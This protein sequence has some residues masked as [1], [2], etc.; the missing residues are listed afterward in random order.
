MVRRRVRQVREER[1]LRLVLGG[2]TSPAALRGWELLDEALVEVG[3]ELERYLRVRERT[4]CGEV[5]RRQAR[6][7]DVTS[8]SDE[9]DRDAA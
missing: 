6:L 1:V 7:L 5:R 3:P 2:L 9:D 4:F 8:Y